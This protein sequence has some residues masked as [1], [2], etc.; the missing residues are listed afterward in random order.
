MTKHNDKK[1]VS[2]N[3]SSNTKSSNN[4]SNKRTWLTLSLVGAALLLIPRRSSRQDS[5]S[6]NMDTN[7]VDTNNTNTEKSNS[8]NRCNL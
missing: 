4:K 3:N 8:N 1:S 6:I 7:N 5:A 2:N